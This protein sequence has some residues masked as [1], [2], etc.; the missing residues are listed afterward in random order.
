MTKKEY[1]NRVVNTFCEANNLNRNAITDWRE[2][3]GRSEALDICL[4]HLGLLSTKDLLAKR[5]EE[6]IQ[7]FF[8]FGTKSYD[9]CTTRVILAHLPDDDYTANGTIENVYINDDTSTNLIHDILSD[10]KNNGYKVYINGKTNIHIKI[11][12]ETRTIHI[13]TENSVL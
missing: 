2:Y 3:M 10:D 13:D 5:R 7:E 9:G 4:E 6:G 11:N 8:A 1:S 12:R